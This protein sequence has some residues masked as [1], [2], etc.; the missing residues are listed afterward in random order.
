M[1][2]G[3]TVPPLHQLEAALYPSPFSVAAAATRPAAPP[4]RTPPGTPAAPL[5]GVIRGVAN[6]AS[7]PPAAPQTVPLPGFPAVAD[8]TQ[9]DQTYIALRRAD[10]PAM[11]AQIDSAFAGSTS[12]LVAVGG[13]AL[14]HAAELPL[15]LDAQAGPYAAGI[16][17]IR[18]LPSLRAGAA[19]Q[20]FD[21]GATAYLALL[22]DLALGRA[23]GAF[24]HATGLAPLVNRVAR[25]EPRLILRF[26]E[27]CQRHAHQLPPEGLE[28]IGATLH[29]LQHVDISTVER[30]TA[31]GRWAIDQ[32]R[33]PDCPSSLRQATLDVDQPGDAACTG[34]AL[35]SQLGLRAHRD[36]LATHYVNAL[37]LTFGVQQEQVP[38]TRNG[39][40]SLL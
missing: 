5:A 4:A 40:A 2:A 24:A 36:A 31:F 27:L 14:R 23:D 13:W 9:R 22:Q 37:A 26:G 30:V 1:P 39:I 21:M 17:L 33:A 29:W 12:R 34:Q 20:V 38:V 6:A 32:S 15:A 8:A 16:A 35:L 3:M 28:L 25:M 11:V 19:A 10:M 7:T 18:S